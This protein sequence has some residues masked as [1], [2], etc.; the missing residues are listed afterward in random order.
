MRATL[1]MLT[2]MRALLG[3]E[4]RELLRDPKMRFFVLVPPLV[5]LFIFGYAATFDVRAARVGL[6]DPRNSSE[7]RELV[8]AIRASG[9]F[10]VRSF[11]DMGAAAAAI[12]RGAIRAVVRFG[13]DFD[14]E[15]V[16]QLIADGSDSNSAQLVVGQL[17]RLI[18]EHAARATGARPLIRI[19]ERAWFNENLDDRNFFIPGII[20]NVVLIATMTLTAIAVVRERELG[21][22]ERLMVTPLS[23]LEF[24][25]GKM[26]PVAGVGLL[27]VL[28]I[29]A[30]GVGWFEVPFRG[31]FF[32]LLLSSVLFFTSTLGLGLLISAYA[33]TQQQATLMGF[34]VIMPLVILSGFAFPIANMPEPV[35]LLTYINPLRYYLVVIRDV[36]LKGGGLAGHGFEYLMMVVLGL[37][38]LGLA[39]VRLRK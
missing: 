5:Q 35:Q 28:L 3:K 25:L 30:V 32:A 27:D 15:P 23:G 1:D 19:E 21:T 24:L 8:S 17:A 22:L 31:S 10:R 37:V 26:I 14:V 38:A 33:H 12:D 18:R 20:A 2:R 11:S 29:T 13:H 34:F 39:A 7:T 4:L 9:E 16:I 6:L 36:Y